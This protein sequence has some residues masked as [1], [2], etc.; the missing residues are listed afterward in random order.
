LG[1]Y[2]RPAYLYILK[3]AKLLAVVSRLRRED[4]IHGAQENVVEVIK[5]LYIMTVVVT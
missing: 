4:T 1:G 2:K 5:L 3:E